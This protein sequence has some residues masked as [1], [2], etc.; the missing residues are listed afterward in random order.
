MTAKLHETVF[1][2]AQSKRSRKA[3]WKRCK[4]SVWKLQRSFS[5][6]GKAS[7]SCSEALRAFLP[8]FVP[9]LFWAAL[10]ICML[11]KLLDGISNTFPAPCWHLQTRHCSARCLSRPPSLRLSRNR[12]KSRFMMTPKEKQ[13]GRRPSGSCSGACGGHMRVLKPK[14]KRPVEAAAELLTPRRGQRK[15]Q[16]SFW[17]GQAL[18]GLEVPAR[19]RHFQSRAA[20]PKVVSGAALPWQWLGRVGGYDSFCNTTMTTMKQLLDITA[21]RWYDYSCDYTTP[22]TKRTVHRNHWRPFSEDTSANTTGLTLLCS[23]ALRLCLH[24]AML[25]AAAG[26]LRLMSCLLVAW[27]GKAQ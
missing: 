2:E 9:R 7:G 12:R 11:S 22:R 1:T 27:Q 13:V 14:Q 25:A 26:Q 5:H 24:R 20:T 6:P 4:G 21:T 3:Q 19:R 10:A 8:R 17:G 16:R 23:M 15:L 18:R